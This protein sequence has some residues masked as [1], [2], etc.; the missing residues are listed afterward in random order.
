M[1]LNETSLGRYP[2]SVF[3]LEG[4][5]TDDLRHPSSIEPILQLLRNRDPRF[6]YI[7]RFVGTDAE[8]RRYLT[9]W[10]LKRYATFPILYLAC[11]GVSGSFLFSSSRRAHAVT[12]DEIEECLEDK[13]RGRV[14]CL[15]ACDSLDAEGRRIERFLEK[16]RALA[17][18][19]YKGS[20]DWMKSTAFELMLLAELQA[21]GPNV[22]GMRAANRR[23]KVEAASLVK[24]L[25]FRMVVRKGRRPA[26]P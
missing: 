12:L 3:C 9:K 17:V 19:G 7:H 25:G 8:L 4:E 23:L 15:G 16:T 1:P 20:V 21:S 14:I 24:S 13:C 2:K 5:W 18:C 10:V 26:S 22:S 6:A 11:H